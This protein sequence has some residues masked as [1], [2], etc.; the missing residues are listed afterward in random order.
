MTP[1]LQT[2]AASRSVLEHPHMSQPQAPGKRHSQES[3]D[4]PRARSSLRTSRSLP[5]ALRPRSL[6]AQD[7]PHYSPVLCTP[8]LTCS[9]AAQGHPS[10]GFRGRS[11]KTLVIHAF[12]Y[13]APSLPGSSHWTSHCLSVSLWAL[14]A[15]PAGSA[16]EP[17]RAGEVCAGE[18]AAERNGRAVA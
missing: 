3:A 17:G 1:V 13:S 9:P 18:A 4:L 8:C 15:P 10:A 5:R 2:R 11:R 12:L 6:C 16:A 14:P 7:P